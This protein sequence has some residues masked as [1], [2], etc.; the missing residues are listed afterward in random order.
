M[1]YIRKAFHLFSN[2][3]RMKLRS[4]RTDINVFANEDIRFMKVKVGQTYHYYN[5]SSNPTWTCDI[6]TR[7]DVLHSMQVK[8]LSLSDDSDNTSRDVQVL[9]LEDFYNHPSL[10]GE[11]ITLDGGCMLPAIESD[12]KN[13]Y[14]V[15]TDCKFFLF[16]LY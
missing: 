6:D 12:K 7:P 14:E 15:M 13:P 16:L 3:D 2:E 10:K 1:N 5:H 8:I 4:T 11:T 9:V